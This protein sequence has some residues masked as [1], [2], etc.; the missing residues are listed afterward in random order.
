MKDPHNVSEYTTVAPPNDGEGDVAREV[1]DGGDLP[2]PPVEQADELSVERRK[3]SKK[4]KFSGAYYYVDV[5]ENKLKEL[6]FMRTLLTVI[7]FMLQIIVLLLPQ[8]GLEY[9]TENIPSYA[10]AY[11]W[12][13]FAM[14]AVSVWLFVMNAVKYKFAKRIPKEYAP[15]RGFARRAYFGAELYIAVNALTF[16]I[17]LSFVCIHFDGWG[18]GAMFICLVATAVAVAARQVTHITLK[19]AELIAPPDGEQAAEQ[20]NDRNKQ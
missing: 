19:N 17:E 13:I 1:A 8:G 10:Y 2:V 16:V 15:K 14:I 18:L 5:E 4:Q 20:A 11:M 9:I 3:K 7:A 6:A 12:I